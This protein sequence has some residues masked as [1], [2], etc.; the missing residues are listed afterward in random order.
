VGKNGGRSGREAENKKN[1]YT[2][3]NRLK[4]KQRLHNTPPM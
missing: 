2:E 1:A 4:K 3:N